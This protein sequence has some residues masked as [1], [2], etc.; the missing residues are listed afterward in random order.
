MIINNYHTHT[1]RCGHATGEDIDYVNYAISLHMKTLGFSC[2]VSHT[3]FELNVSYL[4][5]IQ[6]LKEQFKD[7]IKIL[8]AFECEYEDDLI[9]YYRNLVETKQVDYLIFGNHNTTY[10]GTFYNF[11]RPFK[12]VTYLDVYYETL[13][14]ALDSHLFTYICHPDVFLKGYLKWDEHAINLTHKMGKLLSQYDCYVELSGTG[15]RSKARLKY[16]GEFLPTYPFKEFFKI[17][18]Q[19]PLKFVLGADAHAPEQ[20]NDDAI[21]YIE[22]MKDEL[23]LNTVD[24]INF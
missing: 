6:K 18:K 12:D 13:K 11:I 1:K 8:K 9:P 21:K 4:K 23:E 7:K 22:D 14:K 17:L 10:N 3:D 20:L 19:Y 15:Y 16:N 24:E 5:D 2:H